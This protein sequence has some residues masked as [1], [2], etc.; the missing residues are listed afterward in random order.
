MEVRGEE[1]EEDWRQK[2][3]TREG[4]RKTR[5][6]EIEGGWEQGGVR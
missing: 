5:G 3:E 6:M 2:E 1:G 4:G